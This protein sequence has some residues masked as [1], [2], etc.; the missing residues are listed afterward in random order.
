[1]DDLR[2]ATPPLPSVIAIVAIRQRGHSDPSA[3]V[4]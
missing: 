3:L 2:S 4:H 1:M